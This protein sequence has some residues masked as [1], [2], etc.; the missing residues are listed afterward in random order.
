MSALIHRGIP[1]PEYLGIRALSAGVIKTM[2]Q[3]C[4]KAAWERSWLNPNKEPDF[5][6]AAEFGTVCHSLILEKDDS[7]IEEIDPA[8]HPAGTTGNIPDGWTNK[9]IREARDTARAIGK[10]PLL[11]KDADKARAVQAAA[12]EFID[13]LKETEPAVWEAFQPGGG[14]AESTITWVTDNGVSCKCRPDLISADKKIIVDVK[15]TAMSANPTAWARTNMV[16]SAAYIS[17]AF[18]QQAVERLC[19][20][21]PAYLFLVVEVKPPY[22]CSLIGTDPKAFELGHEKVKAGLDLW[23][24]CIGRDFWPAYPNRVAYPELPVWVDYSWEEEQHGIEYQ[25][26]QLWGKGKQQ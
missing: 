13:T 5:H 25:L 16:N 6:D 4:P 15:T 11:K 1:M 18:Y 9:S 23:A 7:D 14:E 2:I 3:Q 26:E 12:Y 20:I 22:L 17:S 8:D 19:G 24:Q 21:K 10:I